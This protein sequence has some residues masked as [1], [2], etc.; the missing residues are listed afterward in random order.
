MGI[1]ILVI[2]DVLLILVWFFY[3]D[4]KKAIALPAPASEGAEVPPTA[5]S[6]A[7]LA[8]PPPVF[9]LF[10]AP[11]KIPKAWSGSWTDGIQT[12][13]LSPSGKGKIR[14]DGPDYV[15]SLAEGSVTSLSSPYVFTTPF[16]ESQLPHRGLPADGCLLSSPKSANS[17]S[18][19]SPLV[20]QKLESARWC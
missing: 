8:S 11:V 14:E 7:L 6:G 4:E 3:D 15:I 12:I 13:E 9:S 16:A 10:K 19:R 18:T 20:T 1:A 17:K 5:V 2:I